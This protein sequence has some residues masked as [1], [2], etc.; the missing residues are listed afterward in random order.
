MIVAQT[1]TDQDADDPSP[2]APLL[3]QYDDRIAR[4]T[5]ADGAYDG[6]PIYQTVE[7]HG[8]GMEVVIPPRSTAV[9]TGEPGCPHGVIAIW[10]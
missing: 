2:V 3:R 6:A 10:R 7:V 1:L 9:S 4:V 5:T 8:D